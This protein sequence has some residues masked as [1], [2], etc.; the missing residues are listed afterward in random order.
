[1][2]VHFSNPSY[3]MCRAVNK[4]PINY[5]ECFLHRVL[6]LIFSLCYSWELQAVAIGKTKTTAQ[7]LLIHSLMHTYL[8]H[9]KYLLLFSVQ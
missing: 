5:M 1:M 3:T 7:Q 4:A 9:N 8:G 6:Y 2:Y